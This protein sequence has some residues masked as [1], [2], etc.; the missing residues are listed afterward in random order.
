MMAEPK[1]HGLVFSPLGGDVHQ[2][3]IRNQE[4]LLL[5]FSGGVGTKTKKS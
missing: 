1:K 2:K 3:T 5:F 4:M